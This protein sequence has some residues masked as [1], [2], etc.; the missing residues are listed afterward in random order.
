MS[1]FSQSVL[2]PFSRRQIWSGSRWMIHAFSL[3]F[4]MLATT[5]CGWVKLHADDYKDSA[6]DSETQFL[7]AERDHYERLSPRPQNC[8][9]LSG[10]GIR[11]A[12]YSIGVLKG[13]HESGKLDKIDIISAVS[14]GSYAAT[15]LYDQYTQ[16]AS[17]G[18]SEA[19]RLDRVLFRGSI[20]AVAERATHFNLFQGIQ[21]A[22]NFLGGSD[23]GGVGNLVA[24][25]WIIGGVVYGAGLIGSTIPP[26][27]DKHETQSGADYEENIGRVFQNSPN[28]GNR[29]SIQTAYNDFPYLKDLPYLIVNATIQDVGDPAPP[30][31]VATR[32]TR[33]LVNDI[34]EFTS[35]GMGSPSTGYKSWAELVSGNRA[36]IYSFSTIA[37]I[38]GAALH[39]ATFKIS[40]F[41]VMQYF[42]RDLGLGYAMLTPTYNDE[43]IKRFL[44]LTD[45]GDSE[46]L[47]V[48]GLIKRNCKEILVVDAEY[49]GKIDEIDKIMYGE[50]NKGY[51]D[52][53]RFEAYHKLKDKLSEEGKTLM[54]EG[55]SLKPL[56]DQAAESKTSAAAS[57]RKCWN[58]DIN[59]NR[60]WFDCS[61]PV[62]K[63]YVC[64]GKDTDCNQSGQKD[65]YV[66]YAKLSADRELLDASTQDGKAKALKVYGPL[67]TEFYKKETEKAKKATEAMEATEAE[68]TKKAKEAN[69]FPH[70]STFQLNW[71]KEQFLAIAE[72]GCR[73][74]LRH[75][76]KDKLSPSGAN[77]IDRVSAKGTGDRK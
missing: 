43:W 39:K 54:I 46:N 51:E 49:D 26:W 44:L 60:T 8:L 15:W 29:L 4:L 30:Q 38:S 12:A 21:T 62:S 50:S 36:K 65:L 3:V 40:A 22:G 19:N 55:L 16:Q 37:S 24:G 70:Y 73:A 69:Y 63:G 58:N 5:S 61:E 20:E 76:D 1:E 68:K 59:T 17:L 53:Y 77:C 67:I 72:L 6:K 42:G 7:K 18:A 45:G 13:L 57:A 48:Y 47:G 25:D 35:H 14:G 34:F 66:T 10:G 2:V 27:K 41:K 28:N 9:A 31:D 71:D 52:G 75:Y 33:R 11:S 23:P 74:V 56:E 64:N 32:N